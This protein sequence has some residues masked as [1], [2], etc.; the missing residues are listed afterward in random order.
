MRSRVRHGA[1]KNVTDPA[2]LQRLR[3]RVRIRRLSSRSDRHPNTGER[4]NRGM[5]E[6]GLGGM[7][8]VDIPLSEQPMNYGWD[9]NTHYTL[10]TSHTATYV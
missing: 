8:W 6:N 2:P 10:G 5:T 4:T 3:F 7:G 9:M 1:S